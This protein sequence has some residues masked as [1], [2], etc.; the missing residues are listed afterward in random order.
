M[1][2]IT[3]K[4]NNKLTSYFFISFVKKYHFYNLFF[5]YIKKYN[6]FS[7]NIEKDLVNYNYVLYKSLN[8]LENNFKMM[9]DYS[10]INLYHYT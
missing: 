8:E 2:K 6:Y 5:I 4:K 9:F 1:K 7:I 10:T 3:L